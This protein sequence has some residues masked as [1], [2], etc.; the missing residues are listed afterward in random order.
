M[1]LVVYERE[2]SCIT[3]RFRI[4]GLPAPATGAIPLGLPCNPSC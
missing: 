3:V 4:R 2:G 1:R